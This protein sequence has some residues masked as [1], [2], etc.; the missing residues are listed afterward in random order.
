[1]T[2]SVTAYEGTWGDTESRGIEY[3]KEIRKGER[4]KEGRIRIVAITGKA[5]ALREPP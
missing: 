1:M 2:D 3:N 4:G 5:E